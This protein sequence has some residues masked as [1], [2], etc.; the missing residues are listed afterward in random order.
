MVDNDG[1]NSFQSW[2]WVLG[3]VLAGGGSIISNLGLNLQKLTHV[4]NNHAKA[5]AK[6]NGVKNSN[7]NSNS[8]YISSS[9]SA[10]LSVSQ[11]A[12]SPPSSPS[13]SPSPTPAS[14]FKSPAYWR[15]P[16]WVLG[17]ALVIFGSAADFAALGFAAQTIVAPLGS[18]TLVSN[19]FFAPYF[20]SE[21]VSR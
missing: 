16:V 13:P 17:L 14:E 19:V 8:N 1:V 6:Q 5:L 20:S 12:T 3:V 15:Q 21:R 7:N 9:A 4:R 2:R 10:E 11:S 18:L